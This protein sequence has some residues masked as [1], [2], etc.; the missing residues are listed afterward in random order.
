MAALRLAAGLEQGALL[1]NA[2]Q[3]S[4]SPDTP[5][6]VEWLR[7]G[8][9]GRNREILGRIK[10]IVLIDQED[11]ENLRQRDDEQWLVEGQTTV[12]W[13]RETLQ[14]GGWRRVK[15]IAGEGV[16]SFWIIG[17]PASEEV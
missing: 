12:A 14:N 5:A 9:S 16:S 11:A 8:V 10:E 13:L 7:I 2:Y 6:Q 1:I 17:E 15:T 3:V 4:E